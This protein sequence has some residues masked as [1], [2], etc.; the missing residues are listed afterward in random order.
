MAG[1]GD[2]IYIS[3]Q[4]EIITA[5]NLRPYQELP[6]PIR[7]KAGDTPADFHHGWKMPPPPKDYIWRESKQK[8][9]IQ[10]GR[11]WV[12]VADRPH[13]VLAKL[14]QHEELAWF[15][16][17]KERVWGCSWESMISYVQGR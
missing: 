9:N 11:L 17:E 1:N 6:K 14:P 13:L 4:R 15:W 3:H 2:M 7:I 16:H 12:E 8:H 5:E 10:I